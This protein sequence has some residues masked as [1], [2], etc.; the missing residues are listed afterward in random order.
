LEELSK[1]LSEKLDDES[2]GKVNF[3]A[4]YSMLQIDNLQSIAGESNSENSLDFLY[5]PRLAIEEGYL[6]SDI[7]TLT[8]ISN[9][10][11]EL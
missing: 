6:K 1:I 4:D 10:S 3:N 8:L 5:K 11:F 7:T 2:A 9:L